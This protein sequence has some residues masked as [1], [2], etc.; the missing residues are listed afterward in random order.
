MG[1]TLVARVRGFEK[2]LRFVERAVCDLIAG[3]LVRL[4]PMHLQQVG[5]ELSFRKR[6]VEK[7]CVV[8][9]GLEVRNDIVRVIFDLNR[10]R[11]NARKN[12]G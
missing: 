12:I 7:L 4:V 1:E 10:L 2:Q 6:V 8:K 11:G 3:V 5:S 9:V